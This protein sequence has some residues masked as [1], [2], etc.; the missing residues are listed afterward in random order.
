MSTYFS[1]SAWSSFHQ[2]CQLRSRPP[3]LVF[4]ARDYSVC[5]SCFRVLVSRGHWRAGW[6]D[7]LALKNLC[8]N[9]GPRS[10]RS[11]AEN[12]NV[13]GG[14]KWRGGK[15]TSLILQIHQ[16]VRLLLFFDSLPLST[17]QITLPL[18][19]CSNLIMK[20]EVQSLFEVENTSL[21]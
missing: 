11:V 9:Q 20:L 2:T 4:E 18:K 6:N 16:S 1:I 8:P 15:R 7:A 13:F 21:F 14:N 12:A 3:T 5:F 17:K 10:T 19:K